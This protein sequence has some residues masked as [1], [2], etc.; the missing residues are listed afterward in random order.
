MLCCLA[1]DVFVQRISLLWNSPTC[2][3]SHLCSVVFKQFCKQKN[4][5]FK[6]TKETKE[7]C[8]QIIFNAN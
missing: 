6:M 2:V 4:T 1:F 7:L 5:I 8:K 3:T